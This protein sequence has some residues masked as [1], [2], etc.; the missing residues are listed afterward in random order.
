MLSNASNIASSFHFRYRI[1]DFSDSIR[2][3][4]I[5]FAKNVYG[6]N[7]M[8]M[9]RRLLYTNILLSSLAYKSISMIT[10]IVYQS[11]FGHHVPTQFNRSVHLH[12]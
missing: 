12:R 9:C 5:N 8:N 10:M 3:R 2:E 6:V 4:L 11:Y 1:Q 7:T